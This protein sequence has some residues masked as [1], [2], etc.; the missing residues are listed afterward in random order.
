[1]TVA[2]KDGYKCSFLILTFIH[3]PTPA[4]QPMFF[5]PPFVLIADLN[6]CWEYHHAATTCFRKKAMHFPF[7]FP[8]Q[9]QKNQ[10]GY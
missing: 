10:P 5:L 1:M 2:E 9:N 4:N 8:I 3:A 6:K 7:R